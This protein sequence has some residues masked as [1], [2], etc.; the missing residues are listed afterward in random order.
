M[1][2]IPGDGMLAFAAGADGDDFDIQVGEFAFYIIY[3]FKKLGRD[4]RFFRHA[5]IF[6]APA[7]HFFGDC[8][9]DVFQMERK[10]FKNFISFLVS[11]HH[12]YFLADADVRFIQ[13]YFIGTREL[14]RIAQRKE[15]KPAHHSSPACRRSEFAASFLEC[16]LQYFV[17]YPRW[18]GPAADFG[19]VS[20]DYAVNI[21]KAGMRHA[22]AKRG[23]R[24]Q[25]V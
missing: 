7:G 9:G 5:E 4:F 20:F 25:A 14:E 13:K 10:F 15:V 2:T 6:R 1:L 19:G 12:F 24:R 17:S 3:I 8:L 21:A 23:V 11:S 22:Q 18:E 16:L